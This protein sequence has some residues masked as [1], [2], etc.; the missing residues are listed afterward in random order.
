MARINQNPLNLIE[1][2]DLIRIVPLPGFSRERSVFVLSLVEYVELHGLLQSA[3][4]KSV[5][6]QDS[7]FH[8]GD[9]DQQVEL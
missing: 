7:R 1:R 4:T 9:I 2:V 6:F 3:R 8:V 5:Q